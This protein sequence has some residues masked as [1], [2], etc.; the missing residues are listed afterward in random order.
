MVQCT[1]GG[2]PVCSWKRPLLKGGRRGNN[3]RK[4]NEKHQ[5]ELGPVLQ[6]PFPT[7]SVYGP[8]SASL[9]LLGGKL[10][11]SV[12][13]AEGQ[14]GSVWK[15]S[16]LC[17]TNCYVGVFR[18][19]WL[20][21]SCITRLLGLESIIT[22]KFYLCDLLSVLWLTALD[23][24]ASALLISWIINRMLINVTHEAGP[25]CTLLFPWVT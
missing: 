4:R 21:E 25:C 11:C 5:W 3:Y 20:L 7:M 1:Q 24:T 12:L 8:C 13:R 18:D 23:R 19:H 22:G 15:L 6:V 14:C 17:I 9:F 2:T 16:W 10:D